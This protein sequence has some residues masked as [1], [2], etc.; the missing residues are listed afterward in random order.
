MEK[1]RFDVSGKR[2][3]NK[4]APN[5][6]AGLKQIYIFELSRYKIAIPLTSVICLIAAL[7][8]HVSENTATSVLFY[9]TVS[10][11]F[12]AASAICAL[13]IHRD[14][15]DPSSMFSGLCE[16][17]RRNLRAGT[18]SLAKTASC[19]TAAA[20]AACV[21]TVSMSAVHGIAVGAASGIFFFAASFYISMCLAVA[22]AVKRQGGRSG[23]RMLMLSFAGLY[24]VGLVVLIL[25]FACF[26]GI[27]L[28]RDDPGSTLSAEIIIVISL[29]YLAASAIRVIYLFFMLR[30]RIVNTKHFKI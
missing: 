24:T 13:G 15:A 12:I 17:D 5:R 8:T 19:L 9:I 26:S 25:I 6:H 16:A 21:I 18:V 2:K 28:G 11:H 7:I 14:I 3:R 29:F 20:I 22:S 30:R 23:R 4:P 1:G 27:P 10:V